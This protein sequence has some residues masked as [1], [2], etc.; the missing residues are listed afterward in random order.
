MSGDID[1]AML[2]SVGYC[3]GLL[4]TGKSLA[5]LATSVTACIKQSVRHFYGYIED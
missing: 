2:S 5:F 4:H 3:V 1:C